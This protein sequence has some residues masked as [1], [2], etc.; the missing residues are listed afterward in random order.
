MSLTWQEHFRVFLSAHTAPLGCL[1]ALSWFG[2]WYLISKR[3]T[4]E[5]D[6]VADFGVAVVGFLGFVIYCGATLL[7]GLLT[8]V[9]R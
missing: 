2:I 8:G 5:N 1:W 3:L 4:A 9:V 6:P 7:I